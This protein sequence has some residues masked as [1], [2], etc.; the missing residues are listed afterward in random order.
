MVEWV[1]AV[2]RAGLVARWECGCFRGSA[3]LGLGMDWEKEGK[4]GEEYGRRGRKGGGGYG[5]EE[6]ESG[7]PESVHYSSIR[8][9]E[10][11]L[12]G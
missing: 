12:D 8:P 10:R 4:E 1:K 6:A 9:Q 5:G 7:W 11:R 2:A 3:G